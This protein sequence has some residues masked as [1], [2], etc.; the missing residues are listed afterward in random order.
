MSYEDAVH[1]FDVVGI[2]TSNASKIFQNR[3]IH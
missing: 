1:S 3:T 2:L